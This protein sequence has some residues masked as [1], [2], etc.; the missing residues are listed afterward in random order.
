MPSPFSL[1]IPDTQEVV[2]VDFFTSDQHFGHDREAKDRGFPVTLDPVERSSSY[3]MDEYIS[4]RWRE[5]VTEDDVVLVV[6]DVMGGHHPTNIRH[7]LN[8]WKSLPGRKLL[9]PGNWDPIFIRHYGQEV[10]DEFAPRYLEAGFEIL[11]D[12][13]LIS[14]TSEKTGTSHDVLVAHHPYLPNDWPESEN[15]LYRHVGFHPRNTTG[16]PLI[17]GHVHRVH[18]SPDPANPQFHIGLDDHGLRPV[19]ASTV[20][21]WVDSVVG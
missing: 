15:F 1:I 21:A 16:T 17:F 2:K 10:Y 13:V 6:G 20:S 11:P 4:E 3:A 18:P 9:I 7:G 14:Y 19:P 12:E 8:T 5:M